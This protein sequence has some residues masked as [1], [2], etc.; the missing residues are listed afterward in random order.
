MFRD[1][2]ASHN[3][4][5]CARFLFQIASQAPEFYLGGNDSPFLLQVL[6]APSDGGEVDLIATVLTPSDNGVHLCCTTRG[7]EALKACSIFMENFPEAPVLIQKSDGSFDY[8]LCSVNDEALWRRRPV[9][10]HNLGG[11][12]KSSTEADSV[13][14][15]LPAEAS[16]PEGPPRISL[17]RFEVRPDVV[18]D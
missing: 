3:S 5:S 9:T 1:T 12:I 13:A 4:L 18:L 14:F 16:K 10:Y 6:S 15:F 8:V 11:M 17:D 2:V 7:E